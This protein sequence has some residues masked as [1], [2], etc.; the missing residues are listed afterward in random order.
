MSTTLVRRV[1]PQRLVDVANPLVRAVA[2]SAL[3]GLVD[4]AL[5]VLHVTGRRTGRRFDIPVGY[6]RLDERVV[7]LTQHAWRANLRGGVD[8]E[9]TLRGRRCRMHA[10]LDEDPD[11]VARVC[12]LAVELHGWPTARRWLGLATRD[13]HRPTL[14]ELRDA[15]AAFDLAVITLSSSPT[16]PTAPREEEADVA[17]HRPDAGRED[18]DAHD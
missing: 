17:V 1:P 18:R 7:V 15:A 8:V 14:R 5:L 16:A 3:H 4:R 2:R 9:V 6:L 10:D 11:S 12:Q 13:G